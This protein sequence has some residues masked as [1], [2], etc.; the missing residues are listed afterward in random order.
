[1][2]RIFTSMLLLAA[3]I[4]PM[5]VSAQNTEVTI[6]DGTS[7]NNT[8]PYNQYYK[9]STTEMLY[10]A[11]EVGTSGEIQSVAW[12]VASASNHD[13]TQIKIY[14][15]VTDA[16]SLSSG[17]TDFN[18][19][20][21]VYTSTNGTIGE[22]IG[23]ETVTLQSPFYYNGTE[24]LVVVVCRQ[25]ANYTSG[26]KYYYTS[27]SN[28]VR[29]YRSDSGSGYGELTNSYSSTTSDQLPNM[30]LSINTAAA[31][32]CTRPLALAVNNLTATSADLSLTPG[33]AETEWFATITP[34]V[35]NVSSMVIN[36]TSM[37]ITGLTP[38]TTYS[39]NVSSI[40][41]VGDTSAPRTITFTT[42]CVPETLPYFEDFE[43]YSTGSAANISACW[44][45][46][47]NYSTSYPYPYGSYSRE[48]S[49]RNLYFYGNSSSNYYSYAALPLFEAPVNTLMLT[50]KAYKTSSNYGRIYVGVMSDP[51]DINTFVPY[52]TI[53]IAST[54]TW[55]DYEI[56]FDQYTGDG[57][58][59]AFVARDGIGYS[60]NYFVIDD[61]AVDAIPT[62]RKPV[63]MAVVNG[64]TT[65]SSATFSWTE[66]NEATSWIIT[67]SD[68][69]N[70]A[71]VIAN[72][73]P[74]TVTGLA[75]NTPYTAYVRAICAAGD[76]SAASN[77]VSVRTQCFGSAAIPYAIDFNDFGTGDVPYCWDA[78]ATGT[79]GSV[80]FPSCYSHAPNAHSGSIYFEF[81]SNA[82]ATEIAAMPEMDNING[83]E[84]SLWVKMVNNAPVF[85][86]GVMEDTTFVVVDTIPTTGSYVEHHL[87]FTNYTGTGNR[88]AFRTT[89]SGTGT[90]TLF[91]DDINVIEAPACARVVAPAVS[92][93]TSNSATFTWTPGADETAWEIQ[94]RLTSDTAW[95]I[96][97]SSDTSF[98][99]TGL[100][101][102]ASYTAQV[103]AF[104]SP[105]VQG[106]WVGTLNFRTLCGALPLPWQADVTS[107]YSSCWNRYN[108][109]IDQVLGGTASLVSTSSGWTTNSNVFSTSHPKVNIYGT[110]CR[111]WLVTPELELPG[112]AILSFDAAFTAYNNANPA[113]TSNIADDRFAVLML[114]DDTVWTVLRM[115]GSDTTLD[116]ALA[117][118]TNTPTNFTLPIS[119]M[120]GQVIRLAFYAESTVGGG[121]ND[122]HLHNITVEKAPI[123]ARA[124]TFDFEDA[125][126]NAEWTMTTADNSWF[127]GTAANNGGSNG[128]YVS[129]DE[130][131][132]NAYT[133]NSSVNAA[134]AYRTIAIADAEYSYSYNWR[135]SAETNW[136]F[137]RVALIP[138]DQD[139]DYDG[140]RYTSYLPDGWIALDGGSQ[141]VGQ[142]SWQTQEGTFRV[143]EGEYKLAFYWRNDN[144]G[145]S[146]P[147]AAIDN[148]MITPLTCPAPLALAADSIS[149][150]TAL[151]TWT[152]GGSESSWRVLVSDADGVVDSAIV[153]APVYNVTGL[154]ASTTYQASVVAL[155]SSDDNSLAVTTSFTT[156]CE[157]E[158][159]PY[160]ASYSNFNFCWNRYSGFLSGVL[161][162]TA[163]LTSTV[164][165]W[166]TSSSVW[167]EA[168]YK[169]NIYGTSAK[170]WMVI[171]AVNLSVNAQLEFDAA[172][173]TYGGSSAYSDFDND[174]RFAILATT[175]NGSTWTVL[176]SYGSDSSDYAT[177]GAISN[178]GTSIVIPLTQFTNQDVRIAFYAESSVNG[179]DFDLH[180]H[181]IVVEE[182]AACSRPN[183]LAVDS[184]TTT[185]ASFSWN[186]GATESAWDLQYRVVGDSA[187]TLVSGIA[188]T[189]YTLNGLLSA[190]SYEAQVRSVCSATEFSVWSAPVTF[191][192]VICDPEDQCVV[193]FFMVDS[194][195]DGWN[196]ASISL[197]DSVSGIAVQN[198]TVDGS[199]NTVNANVCSGR[200]YQIVWNPGGYDAE[201]SFTVTNAEGA[202]IFSGFG[203][204]YGVVS[205]FV[206]CSSVVPP[207]ID[208][209]AMT[210]AS[211]EVENYYSGMSFIMVDSA[212]TDMFIYEFD[213]SVVSGTVY[214]L[215]DMDVAG[216]VNYVTSAQAMASD[217]TFQMIV[218]GADTTINATMLI[219]NT[220]YV[221]TYTH[222]GAP[223]VPDSINVTVLA[224]DAAMGTVT[225]S[226]R[227]E[228]GETITITAVANAGF[229]FVSWNDGN[230]E[231]TRQIVVE[232]DATYTATFEADQVEGID[233]VMGNITIAT[234]GN[235]IVIKGAENQS[236]VIFDVQ[237]R[238]VVR[239]N[240]ISATAYPMSTTGVYLVKVGNYPAK[241]VVIVR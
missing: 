88:I 30:Q 18:D 110:S 107:G 207:T 116:W 148:I 12:N 93:I 37:T 125:A 138:A 66:R 136:D 122:L 75:A 160:F 161:D 172:V 117:D 181:N 179:S 222:V 196:G 77:T 104:C 76:T 96:V 139:L 82:A 118:I 91:I 20:Q 166:N 158:Q 124:F 15:G 24:N 47:T 109:L 121:D 145:G 228:V 7:N 213:G 227:Y 103:R 140:S 72:S 156:L 230:T 105:A 163:D 180:V 70:E 150:H 23:W 194:Y 208:T 183:A 206:A 85:E 200:T 176:R 63:N 143:P 197:V 144:S 168:H 233:D 6:G 132:T 28:R 126:D 42:P 67:Y 29:Y 27:S 187:W 31:V 152:A 80:I 62:C 32:P 141:R 5:L 188:A 221:L 215:D 4:L 154:N 223:V 146:N 182:L 174:D 127:I 214:T 89:Y 231:A 44:T 11:S 129:N 21:L 45:K 198:L 68:G 171:P 74:F 224:A 40:C 199:T 2:K 237:G 202:E 155:C 22:S 112:D 236:L 169:V 54:S 9:N 65:H 71:S 64:Q 115:W 175:D 159:L 133:N 100:Q 106:P 203:P 57:Q 92:D 48:G 167:N 58:Y 36:T 209:V 210:M 135:C 102:D 219:G 59:I 52:D 8:T 239:E 51:S 33:D 61:V 195:G 90:Y 35:D 39:V 170:Y 147:P 189:N 55:L 220:Y 69:E 217:A 162:G 212:E 157:V 238:I 177:F 26:L 205:S 137:L 173:T 17:F 192:T 226:G 84:L 94:Y 99:L 81:E 235:E 201:C 165:G 53:D 241:K 211:L 56:M 10:L 184:T 153:S 120:E 225:G 234:R 130:G 95:T 216:Y 19:L 191:S 49:A 97:Q 16:T 229:H 193:S 185:S 50:F 131:V 151:L 87:L 43:S 111:Y 101:P 1:M 134:Y 86:Y 190:T 149:A 79:N 38:N 3:M 46:G 123:P 83:L 204:F 60:Y 186:A 240:S 128:L 34:A 41:G 73:N 98:T 142:S 114:T 113:A 25:A 108:G 218:N 178:T 13:Y 119:G 164:G 232:G 78:I 14:M